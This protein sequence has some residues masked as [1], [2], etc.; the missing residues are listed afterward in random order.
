MIA[1]LSLIDEIESTIAHS[2]SRRRAEMMRRLADLFLVN[3]DQYSDDEVALIDDIFVRLVVTIE[4]SARALLAIRL[5]P[6]HK[7]PPKILRALASDDAIDVASP[8]LIHAERLDDATLIECARTKSQEHLL[9]ISRRKTLTEALTDVLVE[10]GDP[11]VVLST[12][13]NAG[14]KFSNNGFA[15]LIDRSDGDDLLTTYVGIRPDLPPQL[16]EHLLEAASEAVRAKLETESPHARHHIHRVVK[17]VAAQIKTE[18]T[19]QSQKYA[20]AQ[21][22][23]EVL[24]QSGQLNADKL[25]AFANEGRFAEVVAV[26]AVMAKMPNEVVERKVNEESAEF[27]LI[28]AKAIGLSWPATKSILALT[29]RQDRHLVNDAAECQKSFLRLHQPTA[30]QILD[31][32]RIR[33]SSTAKRLM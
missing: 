8:I 17:G 2:S 21:V 33:E 29:A 31:F 24:Q 30:Q 11:Q 7:A 20:A 23:V 19:S 25:E 1:Q 9:S 3:V 4:E 16:F 27:L 6:N 12:V 15:I 18:A 13:Q 10:R 26:L 22:L 14:A 5:G 28:L 32:H